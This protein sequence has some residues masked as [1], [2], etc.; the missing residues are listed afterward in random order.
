MWT[1]LTFWGLGSH[2]YAFLIEMNQ[3][4][5]RFFHS[6]GTHLDDLTSR[7]INVRFDRCS[8]Y[9]Y[10]VYTFYTIFPLRPFPICWYIL[11]RITC[12][13]FAIIILLNISLWVPRVTHEFDLK[14]DC[15]CVMLLSKYILHL[16]FRNLEVLSQYISKN[17][18]E[19]E[20]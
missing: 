18:A 11:M 16:F 10:S 5:T 3:F 17:V 14:E 19:F 8:L 6:C 20:H 1:H 7:P 12:F 13:V 15:R 9:I 4:V 2:H